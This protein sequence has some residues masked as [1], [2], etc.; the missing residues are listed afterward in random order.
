[1]KM[2]KQEN[3]I[4]K[5]MAEYNKFMI[6]SIISFSIFCGAITFLIVYYLS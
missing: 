1:M 2:N 5:L 3:Q 6:L 4:E